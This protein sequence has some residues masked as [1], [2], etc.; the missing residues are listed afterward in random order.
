MKDLIDQGPAAALQ[1]TTAFVS[2]DFILQDAFDYT[3]DSRRH[4]N[5]T[6]VVG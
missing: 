3:L 4:R 6:S 2:L 1:I 5:I